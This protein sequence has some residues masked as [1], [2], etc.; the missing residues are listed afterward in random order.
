MPILYK[1]PLRRRA[2]ARNVES[3]SLIRP[4]LFV[5]CY[6]GAA[7]H[8]SYGLNIAFSLPIQSLKIKIERLVK[9][10]NQRHFCPCNK[11]NASNFPVIN[12]YQFIKALS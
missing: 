12:N 6:Q 3:C 9:I 4:L 5:V 8:A 2:F 10:E 11:V 7:T 1:H